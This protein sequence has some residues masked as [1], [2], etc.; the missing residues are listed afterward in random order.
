MIDISIKGNYLYFTNLLNNIV[1]DRPICDITIVKKYSSSTLY[2]VYY[3]GNSIDSL[4][5]IDFSNFSLEGVPFTNQQDFED[6]K[7]L[8]TA[9]CGDINSPVSN[10]DDV[11]AELQLLNA[12]NNAINSNL[13]DLKAINTAIEGFASD[14]VVGQS[15]TQSKID[16]LI[17]A[18]NTNSSN[19]IAELQ[20]I[21]AFV[22]GLEAGQV[23][24]NDLITDVNGY[25]ASLETLTQTLIDEVDQ[26]EE[27][28]TEIRDLVTP[29][30]VTNSF[31]TGSNTNVPSGYRNVTISR[32]GGT[33]T[34]DLGN[35]T[36]Q[37][38]GGSNPRAIS[39]EGDRFGN[40]YGLLPTVTITGGNWQWIATEI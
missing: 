11:V 15:L 29:Q 23:I 24:T 22:D 33:V 26:V 6:W 14:L 4:C 34:I 1:T 20:A 32:L 21:K 10:L 27:L 18:V 35:G 28:L 13:E 5:N 19:E 39:I 37:L 12:S 7:N 3:K 40:Q 8:N 36:F 9:N 2:S 30:T 25:L 38:G 17:L 16:D 31:P